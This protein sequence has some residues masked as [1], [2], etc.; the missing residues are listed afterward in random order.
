MTIAA[1]QHSKS[2]MTRE[3]LDYSL[4]TRG[5]SRGGT[6]LP[7]ARAMIGS[8]PGTLPMTAQG[9]RPAPYWRKPKQ[10]RVDEKVEKLFESYKQLDEQNKF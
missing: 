6:A 9:K 8:E 7:G 10:E 4:Q 2:K 3:L 1:T 5:G